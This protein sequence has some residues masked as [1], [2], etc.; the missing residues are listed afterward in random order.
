MSVTGIFYLVTIK[1]RCQKGGAEE[2]V[3]T[4]AKKVGFVGK[5]QRF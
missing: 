2:E 1:F 4:V 5:N 3:V